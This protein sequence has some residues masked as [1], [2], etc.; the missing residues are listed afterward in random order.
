MSCAFLNC[1]EVCGGQEAP[2][3]PLLACPYT[4]LTNGFHAMAQPLTI[5]QGALAAWKLRGSSAAESDRYLQMSVKQVARLTDL[6]S[7]LGD[8]LDVADGEPA[9]AEIEM[10]ELI[11][12]VLDGMSSVLREWGGDVDRVEANGPIYI[13][14]DADRTERALRAALRA[15][16][17]VASL[18][19]L[20][21]VSVCSCDGQVEVRVESTGGQERSLGFA[22][23]LNLSLAETNIRCQGGGY[24]YTENPLC[25]DF[26][27]PEYRYEE[28]DS[29]GAF[30]DPRPCYPVGGIAEET[31]SS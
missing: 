19:G 17:S 20:I 1:G 21:R 23:R 22:D 14:G 15:A 18:G 2:A 12:L 6:L 10:E 30:R 16:V 11:G 25:I 27:L 3:T 13:Q 24:K 7:S 29:S 5:L 8:V 31:T 26:T 9:R 28:K 4:G